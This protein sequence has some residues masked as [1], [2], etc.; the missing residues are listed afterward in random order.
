MI[1]Q[2]VRVLGCFLL[3]AWLTVLL[4][5]GLQLPLPP[6]PTPDQV[7]D[8]IWHGFTAEVDLRLFESERKLAA[9][10]QLVELDPA[11]SGLGRDGARYLARHH[12]EPEVRA[13]WQERLVMVDGRTE[14]R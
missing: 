11:L 14:S 5:I 9:A 12:A 1:G 6:D 7:L 10:H 8:P 13:Q 4:L 3:A 2:L